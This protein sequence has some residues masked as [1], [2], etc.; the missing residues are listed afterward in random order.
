[1]N[2]LIKLVLACLKA[3]EGINILIKSLEEIFL[4]FFLISF[5]V[6]VF[7]SQ[8]SCQGIPGNSFKSKQWVMWP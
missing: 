2:N 1:M 4:D 8:R 3:I 6:F 7:K 5:L